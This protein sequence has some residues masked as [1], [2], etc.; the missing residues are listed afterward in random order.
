M[1]NMLF[2]LSICRRCEIS[3]DLPAV[4][5]DGARIRQVLLNLLSNAAKF[6][7]KGYVAG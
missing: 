6:T 3:P 1:V 2:F 7:P 5:A 4:Y